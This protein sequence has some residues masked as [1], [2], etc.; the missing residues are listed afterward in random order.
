M[1]SLEERFADVLAELHRL[2]RAA[3]VVVVDEIGWRI[4]RLEDEVRTSVTDDPVRRHDLFLLAV[5]AYQLVADAR[6]RAN[7]AVDVALA[8]LL[9]E[10]HDAEHPTITSPQPRS[11]PE[12]SR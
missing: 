2:D 6:D 1:R 8:Q 11:R 10:Q 3:S 12:R 4:E 7:H 5:E 9:R